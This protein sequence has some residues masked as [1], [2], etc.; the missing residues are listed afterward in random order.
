MRIRFFLGGEHP[1][2]YL[3]G[4]TA[5][6]AYLDA[7]LTP[8]PALYSRLVEQGFRRS[9]ALVY[10][11]HCRNCAA[12]IPIRIPTARFVPDRSQRRNLRNNADLKVTRKPPE[13]AE[14]HYRLFRRYLAARH[15]D[16]A[17][18]NLS[19]QE[20]IG[21]LGSDWANT[22]F[23]EFKAKDRLLAVAVMDRL[24]RGLSAVYTFFD[25][26]QA[27]RGL[28]TQAVLWQIGE[29]RRLGL[30]WLYLGYWIGDCRKMSYKTRF[31]PLE[32]LIGEHWKGFEKGEKILA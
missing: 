30:E 24:D 10:R 7:D 1:C 9:G 22:S 27:A 26:A 21:F 15:G 14:E 3:P 28:G 4:Q 11:P 2:A 6:S 31:R 8:S 32:A 18:A 19:A 17:M 25:P 13:F 12:C 16:G 5:N 23:V 20:Y 29:A